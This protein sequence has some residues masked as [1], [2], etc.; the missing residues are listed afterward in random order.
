MDTTPGTA[1]PS[2]LEILL[3][4][5]CGQLY[6][7][8][9]ARHKMM[10]LYEQ[11]SAMANH[12]NVSFVDLNT[13]ASEII[14][15][16]SRG[17]HHPLL[18]PVMSTFRARKDLVSPNRAHC[19]HCIFGFSSSRDFSCQRFVASVAKL[20]TY[21]DINKKKMK[22][23]DSEVVS[24]SSGAS[25][26]SGYRRGFNLIFS[27]RRLFRFRFRRSRKYSIISLDSDSDC[28]EMSFNIANANTSSLSPDQLN[29]PNGSVGDGGGAP[30]ECPMS[31]VEQDADQFPE[32]MTN[33][34]QSNYSVE[35][36]SQSNYSVESGSQSNSTWIYCHRLVTVL[37]HAHRQIFPEDNFKPCPRCGVLYI[38]MDQDT[39]NKMSCVICGAKFCWLCMKEITVLHYLSP[40][41]CTLLGKKKKPW[42]RKKKILWQLGT[43]VGAPVGITLVASIAIPAMIIG[44]PVWVGRK[45][46]ARYEDRPSRHKHNLAITGGVVASI[47]VAPVIAGLAVGIG[48]P[49]LLGY[50]YGVSLCRS[51]FDNRFDNSSQP[52]R[53]ADR[54]SV[55]TTDNV[56]SPM[57]QQLEVQADSC[58]NESSNSLIE[59]STALMSNDNICS[60][61]AVSILRYE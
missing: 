20:P 51:G 59:H 40:S 8:L 33:C 35:S 12:K 46:H 7:Y 27:L 34:S 16:H 13:I 47:I 49:I 19:Q 60:T 21:N 23:G 11:M 50:I 4:H 3:A 29:L 26:N 54:Q 1:P 41:G 56:T 48:V 28:S 42:S 30:R 38:K 32:V 55:D 45:I 57:L 9:T 53:A 31:L 37:N 36:G 58:S 39:S 17:F 43:L 5:L 25:R 10:D 18:S 22:R 6:H 14:E 24:T 61:R 2:D 52:Y 44:I 15:A